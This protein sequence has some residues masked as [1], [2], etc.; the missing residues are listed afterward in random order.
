MSRYPFVLDH[1]ASSKIMY[2]QCMGDL[3]VRVA[4]SNQVR[5]RGDF[6][7]FVTTVLVPEMVVLKSE[8][9]GGDGA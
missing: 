2:L 9:I 8:A 1:C 6:L 4:D 5:E 7:Y 3:A